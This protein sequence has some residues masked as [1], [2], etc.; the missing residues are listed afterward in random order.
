MLKW[1]KCK[2]KGTG[3]GHD[4]MWEEHSINDIDGKMKTYLT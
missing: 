2:E 3:N 1:R 4:T